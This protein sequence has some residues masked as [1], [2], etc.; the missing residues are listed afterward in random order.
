MSEVKLDETGLTTPSISL[1][2]NT[3]SSEGNKLL[4]NGEE[5]KSSAG[6]HSVGE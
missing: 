2:G 4:W 1:G 3:L 6:G 5:F